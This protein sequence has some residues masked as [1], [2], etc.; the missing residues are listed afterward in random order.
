M[1]LYIPLSAGKRFQMGKGD[2][3]H[4]VSPDIGARHLTMNYSVFQPGHEFPQHI[5]DASADIF[6]VL[7]GGVSVRQGDNYLPIRAGD[8]AYIP[9]GEVHGTVNQTNEQA[10]LISFQSPPDPLLYSGQR[11][12][13]VTGVVPRPPEGHVSTVQIR[14][15]ADGSRTDIARGRKWIA[16]SPSSGT[17]EMVLSYIELEPGGQLQTDAL[18]ES[19][20]VW[21]VKAGAAKVTTDSKVLSVGEREVVF[22]PPNE[23]LSIENSGEDKLALIQCQ[24]PA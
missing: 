21:F 16:A 9:P 8:F 19:E 20:S 11:D 3:Q 2:S 15:L 6:I 13:A 5:H 22:V 1:A 18:P 24:A 12:P 14:Q 7:E 4:L 23:V 17:K 10:I